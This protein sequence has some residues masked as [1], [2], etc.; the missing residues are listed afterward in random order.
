M[1]KPNQQSQAVTSWRGNPHK[2][3]P[4]GIQP[5]HIFPVPVS[6][7]KSIVPTTPNVFH[8]RKLQQIK[9]AIMEPISTKTANNYRRVCNAYNALIVQGTE[10]KL[11]IVCLR[12]LGE[13]PIIDLTTNTVFTPDQKETTFAGNRDIKNEPTPGGLFGNTTRTT[14]PRG[15]FGNT[16][17][18]QASTSLAVAAKDPTR[19]TTEQTRA[20]SDSQETQ[21]YTDALRKS[22]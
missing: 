12:T 19:S 16:T 11:A 15:L 3:I 22:C 9:P 13:Y 6:S 4:A 20:R 8:K 14:A 1:K 21:E 10:G 2:I 7:H 5:T 18:P 17:P